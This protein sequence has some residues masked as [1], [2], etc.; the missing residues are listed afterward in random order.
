LRSPLL[1]PSIE[2][3]SLFRT[4][5]PAVGYGDAVAFDVS[6]DSY[7]RFMGRYSVLL[8]PQ[9]ADLAGVGAGMRVVDVGA[10]SGVLTAELVRRVGAENVAAIDPSARLVGA[11]RERHPGVDVRQGTA[12]QL[13][14]ADGAFDA[15]LAQLVVNFMHDPVAGIAEMGRVTRSGGAVA[16]CVWDLDGGRS[17]ISPFWRAAHALDPRAEDESARPGGSERSMRSLFAQAGIAEVESS[18]LVITAHHDSFEDWWEPFALD[19]G[20]AGGYLKTLDPALRDA[21]RERCRELMPAGPHTI[22]WHA[23]AARG[24]AP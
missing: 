3:F 11:L 14:Y 21:I 19:V 17:P 8:A 6:A 22:E 7:D 9:L 15:A 23:W 16:A 4:G 10:G 20:P 13:P 24:V 1:L 12:E 2:L 18:D 5:Y